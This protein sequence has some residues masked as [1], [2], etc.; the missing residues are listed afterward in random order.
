MRS[1]EVPGVDSL[2]VLCARG[3]M[4]SAGQ[5]FTRLEK[6]GSQNH[7][8]KCSQ[9]TTSRQC[10]RHTRVAAWI[11]PGSRTAQQIVVVFSSA[12]AKGN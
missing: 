6:Q 3:S 7:R 11:I 4:L 12:S 5:N 10:P 1:A 8:G 2:L 9:C